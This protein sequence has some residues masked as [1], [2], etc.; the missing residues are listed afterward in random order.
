MSCRE[1]YSTLN[2]LTDF[3]SAL[4]KE[5]FKNVQL[6][7]I[8]VSNAESIKSAKETI[9]KQDGKLDVLVNNAGKSIHLPANPER[10]LM[11]AYP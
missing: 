9:E 6:V 3:R 2:V 11:L 8:D 4:E 10:T 5:G 7:L 1:T